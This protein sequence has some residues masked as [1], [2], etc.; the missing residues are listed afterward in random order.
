MDVED[1]ENHFGE[2]LGLVQTQSWEIALM[3]ALV[4]KIAFPQIKEFYFTLVK[5]NEQ[6][7]KAKVN[8][9]DFLGCS[10]WRRQYILWQYAIWAS[11]EWVCEPRRIKWKYG[12][13]GNNSH[14]PYEGLRSH[15]GDTCV[16]SNS[17]YKHP[18]TSLTLQWALLS[19]CIHSLENT[20]L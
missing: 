15:Q 3:Y 16:L 7:Y 5:V 8:K 6:Y 1:L 11:L 4:K 18:S 14:E 12:H 19:C 13:H 9:Q 2:F 10:E 17:G 20:S